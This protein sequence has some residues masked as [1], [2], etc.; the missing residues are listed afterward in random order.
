MK[1]YS[2]VINV[3]GHKLFWFVLLFVSIWINTLI[4]T[5]DIANW[6][7]ENT[8][9]TIALLFLIIT[10]KKH[11]FS[12]FSYFL[13]CVFLCLHVYG[14]EYTYAENP[15]GFWLQ[16]VFNSSRNHYDRLV[17]F[18]FGFLLYYPIREFYLKWLKFPKRIATIIPVTTIFSLSALYEIIEWLV[19]DVFFVEQG[20]S[21]LGTQGDVWDAQKDMGI[22]FLGVVISTVLFWAYKS[23]IFKRTKN[24]SSVL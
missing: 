11:R 16:D 3:I 23:I 1:L 19:A 7:I 18:C 13:I 24:N 22:A 17:H 6:L 9:T 14:S 8:L 21:Y 4:G 12:D 15:F 20:I 5:T 2:S 10:Y